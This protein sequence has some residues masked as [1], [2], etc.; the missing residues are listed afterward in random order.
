MFL[1]LFSSTFLLKNQV[2]GLGAFLFLEELFDEAFK[3]TM[4]DYLYDLFLTL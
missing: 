4:V 1:T 2:I 3:H